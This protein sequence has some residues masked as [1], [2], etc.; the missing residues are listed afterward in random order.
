VE[1]E[2]DISHGGNMKNKHKASIYF[3]TSYYQLTN[4]AAGRFLGL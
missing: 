2:C 1:F 3:I 4:L